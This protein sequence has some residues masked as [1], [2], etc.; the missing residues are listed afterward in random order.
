MK[1]SI[2]IAT[3]KKLT[4]KCLCISGFFLIIFIWTRS[5]MFRQ[6]MMLQWYLYIEASLTL[7]LTCNTILNWYR[8]WSEMYPCTP[9]SF[10]VGIT[11]MLLVSCK[12]DSVSSCSHTEKITTLQTLKNKQS[13]LDGLTVIIDFGEFPWFSLESLSVVTSIHY[14]C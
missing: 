3:R 10:T 12:V 8:W 9:S 2:F 13:K 4:Q 6:T 11:S 14:L 7:H 1:E 5:S